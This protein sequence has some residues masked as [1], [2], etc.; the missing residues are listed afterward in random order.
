MINRCT[1]YRNDTDKVVK[2]IMNLL[3][4]TLFL[5]E[6]RR[7]AALTDVEALKEI[8]NL[9]TLLK[10]DETSTENGENE[11]GGDE[12]FAREQAINDIKDFE[13][14]IAGAKRELTKPVIS[15]STASYLRDTADTIGD[16]WDSK[17]LK[18]EFSEK[19]AQLKIAAEEIADELDSAYLLT[20]LDTLA[21]A[22]IRGQVSAYDLIG[23]L[24]R[25]SKE[26]NQLE[27]L[28]PEATQKIRDGKERAA[29]FRARKKLDDADIAE[30]AGKITKASSL[31]SEAQAMLK[32]DWKRAF[33]NETP[34]TT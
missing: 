28:T 22:D 15:D 14:E 7:I 29:W 25:L 34:P 33:K 2:L 16:Y 5:K 26:L 11:E 3:T 24:E 8:E 12:Q 1:F 30:A 18:A 32:L 10:S 31:R 21:E 23:E 13:N 19:I 27:A 17:E 20:R 4:S 6:I 9:L